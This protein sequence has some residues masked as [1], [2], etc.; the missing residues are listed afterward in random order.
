MGGKLRVSTDEVV[1]TI[2]V[3]DVTHTAHYPNLFA[4]YYLT[5]V[6]SSED[7]LYAVWAVGS[8]REWTAAFL[9]EVITVNASCKAEAIKLCQ[10]HF[11]YNKRTTSSLAKVGGK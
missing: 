6:W 7:A 3:D 5:G 4:F 10:A 8:H 2:R 1:T 9:S 11:L